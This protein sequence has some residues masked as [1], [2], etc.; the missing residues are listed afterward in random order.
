MPEGQAPAQ[1]RDGIE[2]KF[3]EYATF[4]ARGED[5]AHAMRAGH[6]SARPDGPAPDL[7]GS[8][9]ML[10]AAH[11]LGALEEFTNRQGRQLWIDHILSYQA[12]DGWFHSDDRQS[13]G[14]EHATAY[15]L[16]GLQILAAGDGV[17]IAERLKPFAGL[18]R[19]IQSEPDASKPP[20]TLSTLQRVHFWRGS[21]RAGGLAA[22]VGAAEDL[23]LP[24]ERFLGLEDGRGWLAGWWDYFATRVDARTGYWALASVPVR[25]AFNALYQFRHRPDLAAMGGAVHLYWISEKIGADMPYPASLIPATT[26][27]MQP[28]GLYE[29]EPY[30]IDLDANF[31]IARAIDQIDGEHRQAQEGKQA[32]A[33]NR[34]AVLEWFASRTSEDWSFNSHKVP[35]AFAA[36]AEADRILSPRDRRWGDIFET[37]WWL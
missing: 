28:D 14:V 32:L 36:V 7:F 8:L 23:G 1:M 20:F 37:T 22:I 29:N 9:D 4:R 17:D 21:H 10:Y 24:S 18:S 31:L 27:L 2:S 34:D 16:G 26:A 11:I 5:K 25:V 19:E 12:D 35:G 3:L 6:F 33:T 30:C 13:H 15:A